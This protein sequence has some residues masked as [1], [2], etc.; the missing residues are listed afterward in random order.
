MFSGR[1]NVYKTYVF[2]HINSLFF[3]SKKKKIKNVEEKLISCLFP[4]HLMVLLMFLKQVFGNEKKKTEHK[5]NCKVLCTFL[6]I[7]LNCKSCYAI[8]I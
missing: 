8:S 1:F 4:D 7:N 6:R 3:Y 5:G 2:I